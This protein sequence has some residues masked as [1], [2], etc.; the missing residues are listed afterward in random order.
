LSVFQHDGVAVFKLSESSP[1][2]PALSTKDLP[3]GRTQ[4][5][6]VRRIC[7]INRHPV[8]RDDASA[9]E[10]NSDTDDCLNW[11]RDLDN[12][13]DSEDDCT[14]GDESDIGPNNGIEDPQSPEQQGVSAVPLV[15]GIVLPTWKSTR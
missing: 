6:N 11:N 12:P 8:E 4:I 1:L 15:L 9:P 5:S 14:A 2:P 10:S 3:G 13:N 7:K